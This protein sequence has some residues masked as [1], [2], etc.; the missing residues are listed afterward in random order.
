M[1]MPLGTG[2]HCGDRRHAV[3]GI[4]T[5]DDQ[6]THHVAYAPW[7]GALADRRDGSRDL[8]PEDVRCSGRWRVPPLA[9]HH[10]RVID[11]GGSNLDQHLARTG[12]WLRP[13]ARAPERPA[14]R[15]RRIRSQSCGHLVHKVPFDERVDDH[16][17][18]A[19][20][21]DQDRVQ[22]DGRNLVRARRDDLAECEDGPAERIEIE[23]R[24]AADAEKNGAM[25][26]RRIAAR[27]SSIV[28]GGISS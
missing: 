16:H 4:A 27:A 14:L 1:S 28:T 25:R 17:A 26:R 19:N 23:R 5:P 24:L 12:S 2:R 10:I 9:L 11:T 21:P 8:E 15:L 7:L 6:R 3:L 20:T 22:V 13:L 18:L